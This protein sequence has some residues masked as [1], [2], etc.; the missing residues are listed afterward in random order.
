VAGII[1]ALW[2]ARFPV[3]AAP[4]AQISYPHGLPGEIVGFDGTGFNGA[5]WIHHDSINDPAE[6]LKMVSP[7]TA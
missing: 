5:A 2:G 3:T 7:M 1:P 4:P 6:R